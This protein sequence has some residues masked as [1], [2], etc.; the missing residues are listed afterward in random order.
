MEKYYKNH[1]LFCKKNNGCVWI[2]L[3]LKGKNAIVK[4]VKKGII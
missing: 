4:C 2:R 1:R 3:N